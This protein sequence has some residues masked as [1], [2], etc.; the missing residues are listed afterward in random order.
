MAY[1]TIGDGHISQPQFYYL[2]PLRNMIDRPLKKRY[3]S[4]MKLQQILITRQRIG[5]RK[6]EKKSVAGITVLLLTI[7]FL[8]ITAGDVFSEEYTSLKNLKSVKAVFDMRIGDPQSA[9]LHLKL[10]HDTF[11]DKSIVAITD[12]PDF[13]VVLIGASVKLVSTNKEGFSPEQQKVIDEIAGIITAMSKDGIKLEICM[14]AA[15]LM[16]VEPAS[17]LPEIKQVGNGWISLIG[18]QANGYSLVPAY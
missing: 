10:I 12:K 14:V 3:I 2:N 7:C 11:K 13:A 5:G 1:Q 15:N 9:A 4:I 8:V 16:G 6:L 17:I 18:Y